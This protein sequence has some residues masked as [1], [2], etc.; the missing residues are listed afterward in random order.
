MQKKLVGV[1]LALGVGLTLPAAER[2]R[3]AEDSGDV[4]DL[5]EFQNDFKAPIETVYPLYPPEPGADWS[6]QQV[7]VSFVVDTSGAVSEAVAMSGPEKFH[8]AALTAVKQWKFQP[9]LEH[10]QPVRRARQVRIPFFP[11]GT[12]ARSIAED[13]NLTRIHSPDTVP[14]GDP[15]NSEPLYPVFLQ[16]R[17]LSGNVELMLGINA[18]G[19]VEGVEVGRAFHPDFLSAALD[20]VAAW[21]CR[22]ARCGL[23]NVKGRKGVVL[24][25]YTTNDE[26]LNNSADWMERNGIFLREPANTKVVDY[27]DEP[28]EAVRMVDPV[29]PYELAVAGTRGGARVDFR[30]DARGRVGEV[31]VAEA[32]EPAFGQALAAAI[33]AWQ[34]QP[35]RRRG[36]EVAALFSITWRFE[37]PRADSAEQRLLT[38]TGA[39]RPVGG[40]ELD[41]PLFPLFQ[42]APIFPPDR[43]DAGEG[44][45]AE[46][47]FIVDRTG[48]VRLPR[49]RGANQPSFGWAAATALS[50]WLFETPLKNGQP[51]DVRVAVPMEFAP[52]ERPAP[53]VV[54]PPD[55]DPIAAPQI[56]VP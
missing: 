18:D 25:F 5:R 6:E 50:Q 42:R 51:V 43:L 9:I 36:E 17:R 11:T 32:T 27:F 23:L 24:S 7:L 19:R 28:V 49:L 3:G 41:R 35:L 46:I 26:G 52:P 37:A 2:L 34:F 56:S 31:A 16:S 4:V 13:Y 39:D 38:A 29:Y 33:T 22:P 14:P 55:V 21:E 12:P 47:E 20:T 15:Y 45:R 53:E 30:I 44:G 54:R 40:R 1:L 8:E 48:R 10:G